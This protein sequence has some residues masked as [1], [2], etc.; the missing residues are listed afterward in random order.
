M[1]RPPNSSR[2]TPTEWQ[3]LERR[4]VGLSAS[5]SCSGSGYP[6]LLVSTPGARRRT[7]RLADR[8]SA[9]PMA[10]ER[11]GNRV[12]ETPAE[13]GGWSG[14]EEWILL[15]AARSP[16]P[17]AQ[18]L[19]LSQLCTGVGDLRGQKGHHLGR[20]QG[21]DPLERAERAWWQAR[22]CVLCP[23]GCRTRS[24]GFR[25]A[26]FFRA[27]QPPAPLRATRAITSQLF[28][29]GPG[30]GQAGDY[31]DQY[32]TGPEGSQHQLT[33]LICIKALCCATVGQAWGLPWAAVG[34][35]DCQCLRGHQLSENSA[36][37]EDHWL[38]T[39]FSV[40]T[41]GCCAR[42]L[43]GHYTHS[44]HFTNLCLNGRRLPTPVSYLCAC[45]MGSTQDIQ[46]ECTD[47]DE[48]SSSP[49]RHGDCSS[50]SGSYHCQCREDFEATLSR[51]ACADVDKCTVSSGCH[52]SHCLNS[53]GTFQCICNAGFELR[54]D[55][56]SCVDEDECAAIIVCANGVCLNEDGRFT[57]LCKSG[58]LLAQTFS[59]HTQP[60]SS[61]PQVLTDNKC[62]LDPDVCVNGVCENL[63]GSYQCTCHLG[64]EAASIC[65][66]PHPADVDE[67]ALNS[68]LCDSEWGQN[69]P[70]SYSCS[71]PGGFSL[72]LDTETC[73]NINECLSNLCV[74]GACW[75]LASSYTCG[76]APGSQ[77]GPLGTVCLDSTKVIV[78]GGRCEVDLHG[79]TLRSECCATLGAAW[80]SPCECCK[81]DP[82]CAHGSACIK[83][84]TCEDVNECVVFPEVCPSGHCHNTAGSFH[85]ECPEGLTLDAT[86]WLCGLVPILLPQTW[87]SVQRTWISVMVTSV[88]GGHCCLCCDGF[89]AMLHVRIC[90]NINECDLNPH[91]CLHGGCEDMKGSFVCHCQLVYVIRK[92]NMG[93][94]GEMAVSNAGGRGSERPDVDECELGRHSCDGHASCL[95]LL[96]SFSYKC[97]PDWVGDG[98]RCHD[99]DE[100]TFQEHQCRPSTDCFKAP[101]SYYCA[102]HLGFAGDGFSCEEEIWKGEECVED[103]D[104]CENG[105]GLNTPSRYRCKCEMGFSPTED[106]PHACQDVDECVLDLCV[107]RSCENLPRMFR[108]VCDKGYE[109]DCGGHNCTD[110]NECANPV[111]CL[112]GLY[113]N[114]PGSYLCS[115]QDFELNPSRVGCVGGNC[116][117]DMH[118]RD[119]GISCSAEIGVG[120]IASCCCSLGWAWG[121]PCEL[122]PTANTTEY[123]TLCPGGKGFQSKVI[124]V[125]LEAQPFHFLIDIDKCQ[126]LPGLFPG[127]DCVNTFGSFQCECPSGYHLHEATRIC[128]N[129]DECSK[130][131]NFCLFGTCT[132]SPGG[133]QCLCPPGFVL[134][135]HG[136]H[137]FDNRQNFCFTHFKAGRCSVLKAFNTTKTWCCCSQRPGEGWNDPCKLC[138]QEGSAAFQE[139]CPFGHGAV[140]DPDATWEDVNECAENPD[141]CANGLCV[142]TDGSFH[143]ECPFGYSLDFT[144]IRCEVEDE[145][146]TGHPGEEGTCMNIIGVECAC[147]DGFSPGSI[148]TCEDINECSLNPLLCAF[149]HGTKGSV[150][151]CLAGCTLQ[152]VDV[153]ECTDG[154]QDCRARDMPPP[155]PS[156]EEGCTDECRTQPTSVPM[157]SAATL[158]AAFDVTEMRV[159]RPALPSPSTTRDAAIDPQRHLAGALLLQ[160]AA[161]HVPDPIKWCTSTPRKLCPHGSGYTTEGQ[162]VDKFYVLSHLCPHSECINNLGSFHCH[163]QSRY[164]PGNTAK[165][166]L[167]ID[168]SQAPTSCT[169]LCRNMEGNFLCACP[170]C[171]LLQEDGRTCTDLDE[172]TSR[173]H[174]CQFFC[175]NTISAFVCC[176]PPGFTP[177]HQACFDNDECLV[178]G[179]CGTCGCC[180][181]TPGSFSCE[182]YQGF[183]VDDSSGHGCEDVDEC[184]GPHC[185]QHGCQ[186][187][188][189]GYCSSCS[190]GFTHSQWSPCVA[191][192]EC[193][194]GSFHCCPSG[195]GFD[196]T[197]GGCQDVDECAT[198]GGPCSY[199]CS[200]T[201]GG[202]LCAC[203]QDYFRVGQGHCVSSLSFS[204]RSQ[205]SPDEE[206]LLSPEACYECKIKDLPP[207]D[208]PQHSLHRDQQVS[209]ISLDLEALLTLDLNLSH[210]GQA[211]HILELWPALESL[212]GQVCYVIAHG[213]EQSFFRMH[214]LCGLSSLQ[215]EHRRPGPGTHQLEVVS[216][217]GPWGTPEGQLGPVVALRLKGDPDDELGLIG[218]GP[219]C[220]PPLQRWKILELVRIH[221]QW[222]TRNPETQEE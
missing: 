17:E 105:Q 169:F 116:F 122:C 80:G 177:R 140:S 200:N 136:P 69:S 171:Y 71:C 66:P 214:H 79:A 158:K 102:C 24:A 176:C 77:L 50:T 151:A 90:F 11:P 7:R 205:N 28:D 35:Y 142:N 129:I 95:N 67:C 193:F 217:A 100:C 118:Y 128:Q 68:L 167:D 117:L 178:P 12:G 27:S 144:S 192:C 65:S 33:G 3:L 187:E 103:V 70:G 42:N 146:S 13:G 149:C 98:F 30:S 202:F 23:S 76:C 218:P 120:V 132:S 127:G 21:P 22:P 94:F 156:S 154:H 206:E 53:E 20:T 126:E 173:Q 207:R 186:N 36:K 81:I 5:R 153:D 58:F 216:I 57:C 37:C 6:E 212:G 32:Q 48:C 74:N 92:G 99:L 46:G 78:Q 64:Y 54:S 210:L 73:K 170:H 130:E 161:I 174:N 220:H 150:C 87:M 219:P 166:C 59:L 211:E 195:F 108:C 190:Q 188:L 115:F 19:H 119:G 141:V 75:K 213:S 82:A 123:R 168:E 160:G 162:D 88:P 4:G 60:H 2:P 16:H 198:Q 93:C 40:P 55:S 26:F 109:L 135:D 110:V 147:T 199:S 34:S 221:A 1:R 194:L 47:L 163:Y 38:G 189:G 104:L 143:C 180:H 114:T 215:L 184:A 9:G 183:T 157:A 39:C 107:F 203:P 18:P 182:C 86:G 84:L 148:M 62:T 164:M 8:G 52:H 29:G 111:N 209:L 49:C 25:R 139:L 91:I 31:R 96:R 121:N 222:L 106:Q 124:T 51:Q 43:T 201:P 165:T 159:S 152:E 14:E 45:N 63:L 133:F 145:S 72:Q 112:N 56:K 138:P 137:C 197:L 44:Q 61:G 125:I 155:Q 85:W 41:V 179:L 208:Q 101:V 97:H 172:C 131:P 113:V 185:C 83:G 10:K 175:V 134:S 196:Q 15:F 89:M 181:N 204:H 191:E